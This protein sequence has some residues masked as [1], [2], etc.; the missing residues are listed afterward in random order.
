[1]RS[2]QASPT[3]KAPITVE[4]CEGGG[5]DEEIRGYRFYFLNSDSG[6]PRDQNTFRSQ[7][8]NQRQVF[9]Q[10][11]EGVTDKDENYF[12]PS[13][14]AEMFGFEEAEF[15]DLDADCEVVTLPEGILN[16]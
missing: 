14:I 15:D 1:M 13:N 6:T 7:P 5:N 8:E 2:A 11:L 3:G 10:N 9:D 12:T 16:S 4:L